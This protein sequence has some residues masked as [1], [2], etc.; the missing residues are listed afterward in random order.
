ME[1]KL[2]ICIEMKQIKCDSC[3]L[4]SREEMKVIEMLIAKENTETLM[5]P[6]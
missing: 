5:R 1:T 3:W 6:H 4:M 2:L